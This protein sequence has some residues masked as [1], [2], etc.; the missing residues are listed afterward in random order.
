LGRPSNRA[1]RD[2]NW[3]GSTDRTG[4]GSRSA[5]HSDG[6][7]GPCHTFNAVMHSGYADGRGTRRITGRSHGSA[8]MTCVC[9]G[10][11]AVLGA[12]P[13][14]VRLL[15]GTEEPATG[16][17]RVPGATGWSAGLRPCKVVIGTFI[18]G[19]CGR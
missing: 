13:G 10:L 7:A 11:I 6:G 14:S 19:P 8:A 12:S 15:K 5:L 9:L 4:L 1:Q 16:H 17:E 18:L 2:P 3:P